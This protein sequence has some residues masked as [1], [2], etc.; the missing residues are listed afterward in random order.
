MAA[1]PHDLSG[2]QRAPPPSLHAPPLPATRRRRLFS[3]R[4]VDEQ[5]VVFEYFLRAHDVAVGEARAMGSYDEASGGG[6]GV[7]LC[8]CV[9]VSLVPSVARWPRVVRRN[10]P[11]QQGG[12]HHPWCETDRCLVRRRVDSGR[13]E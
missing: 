11:A 1:P 5:A 12:E 9:M 6:W 13:V 3:T 2:R 8:A 4:Q 10:H 7:L